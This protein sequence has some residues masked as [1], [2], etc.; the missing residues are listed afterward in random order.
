VEAVVFRGV[1]AIRDPADADPPTRAGS[2]LIEG[3]GEPCVLGL[4]G[5]DLVVERGEVGPDVGV[6]SSQDRAAGADDASMDGEGPRGPVRVDD[7][8]PAWL[9]VVAEEVADTPAYL[10]GDLPAGAAAARPGR[11]L[12][13]RVIV[14]DFKNHH[15]IPEP[16]RRED[17][18]G[19]PGHRGYPRCVAVA[20]LPEGDG[21]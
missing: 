1:S 6:R 15:H 13:L 10:R 5:E 4:H 3:P 8:H 9:P 12:L 17:S 18:P 7:A 2:R 19:D 11:R 21:S 14:H 20:E 16:D